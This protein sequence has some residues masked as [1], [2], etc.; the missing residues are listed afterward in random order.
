MN[1]NFSA[2]HGDTFNT[3]AEISEARHGVY[4]DQM[5]LTEEDGGE[6]KFRGGKGIIMDYRVRSKNAWVSV[7]YTRSKSLPW[8]LEGGREGG[9]NY[10]EI[11]RKDGKKERYSVITVLPLEPEDVVRIHT[12]NGGGY[13]NPHDRDI[14]LIEN[15]L[16]NEYITTEQAKKYYNYKK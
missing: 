12:G 6:G 14:K 3:P 11:I 10:V 15:D 1:A 7:A 9:P 5:R 2:F 13:G 8:S 16:L 4:V